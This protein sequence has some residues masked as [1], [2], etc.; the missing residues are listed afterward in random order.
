MYNSYADQNV[1]AYK[2][3]EQLRLLVGVLFLVVP[4]ADAMV[5]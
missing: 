3:K 2:K 5:S 1:R 4:I